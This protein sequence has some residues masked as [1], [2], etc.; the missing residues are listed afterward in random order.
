MD[1]V[2]NV[3]LGVFDA[4]LTESGQVEVQLAVEIFNPS[5]VSMSPMGDL[6][7]DMT[8]NNSYMGTLFAEDVSMFS[9]SNIFHL[10]GILAKASTT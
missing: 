4:D 9:G 7:F 10:H 8:Y 5:I 2:K 1:G 3:T 6:S